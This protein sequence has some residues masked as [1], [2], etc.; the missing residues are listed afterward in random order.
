MQNLLNEQYATIL[1]PTCLRPPKAGDLK[2]Q[3]ERVID[4]STF[5]AIEVEKLF[6]SLNHTQ[7]QIGSAVLMRS[8][9]SPLQR[10]DLLK[11]KQAAV[12]EIEADENLMKKIKAV[13]GRAKK[14]EKDLYDLLY[15]SFIGLVGSKANELEVEGYGYNSFIK[16]TRL[17]TELVEGAEAVGP[18]S[19]PYLEG[20]FDNLRD[21]GKSRAYALAKGPIYRTEKGMIPQS[22]RR[23]Y[24]PAIRFNPS[25]FKPLGL[26]LFV[27]G[28][29]LAAEFVPL[30]MEIVAEI[31]SFLWLFLFPVALLYIPIVGGFDRDGCIYP[32]RDYLRRAP[33]LH[34][35]LDSL[36]QLD[37]LLSMIE[38]RAAF[39]HPMVMP[40]L[41]ASK[42]HM[43]KLTEVR[44]PILAKE[45]NAYVGNDINLENARLTLITGPNSGGKTAFCKTLA[46]TQLMAQIGSFVPAESA[47]MTVADRIYYQAPEISQLEDG[48][49]RFGTEL[50]RTKAIF[51]NT[52]PE[53]L[54]IMDEL[55]EGTTH[56]EKIEISRTILDGFCQRGNSTLLITHNH[57]LVDEYKDHA[58]ANPRQVEFKGEQPTYRVV[59]GISRVSHAGR[60]ARKIGFAKEDIDRLLKDTSG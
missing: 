53:S 14:D 51:V 54:V 38:H 13:V 23:W 21:F 9:H 29:L 1:N 43:L 34:R 40:S 31:A 17:L 25:L 16:G 15:G 8:L 2:E 7:T 37:E 27:V 18:V 32:T 19:S 20:I 22:E 6:Q 26:T 60:V 59:S 36:G 4:P 24:T 39:K 5:R 30:V 47:E 11:A 44:N 57:S 49:G 58:L 55:S 41:K 50:K 48:E 33:E 12:L 3:P 52:S 42:Q 28:L 10:L 56:E 46:Q 35:A 45:N